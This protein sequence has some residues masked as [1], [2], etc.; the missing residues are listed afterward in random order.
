MIKVV[1]EPEDLYGVVSAV[2]FKRS[3][4][5]EG[6]RQLRKFI[7]GKSPP[8]KKELLERVLSGPAALIVNERMVNIPQVFTRCGFGV[9]GLGFGFRVFGIPV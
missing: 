6:V 7:L 5:S 4:A 2:S 1:D 3:G 9:W 8:G